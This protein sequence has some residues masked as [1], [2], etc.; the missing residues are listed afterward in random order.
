MEK[1]QANPEKKSVIWDESEGM[2]RATTLENDLLETIVE[3]IKKTGEEE[4]CHRQFR[5]TISKVNS[6]FSL[7]QCVQE[8][9]NV[10]IDVII[11]S[12]GCSV[13]WVDW[14]RKL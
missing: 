7:F 10:L 4:D 1:D 11:S 9:S 13:D 12:L 8:L 3:D 6:D 14:N 5:K 2:S